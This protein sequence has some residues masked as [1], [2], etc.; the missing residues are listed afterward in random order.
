MLKK[1]LG[2]SCMYDLH[3][4]GLLGYSDLL[5]SRDVWNFM[6]TSHRPSTYVRTQ[7]ARANIMCCV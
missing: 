4:W 3:A 5:A 2:V 7:R 1:H 6:A